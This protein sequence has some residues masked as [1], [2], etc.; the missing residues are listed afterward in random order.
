M[1]DTY[2][3]YVPSKDL[4][5]AQLQAQLTSQLEQEK[6]ELGSQQE[7]REFAAQTTAELLQE[8]GEGRRRALEAYKKTVQPRF[9]EALGQTQGATARRAAEIEAALAAD[10][11][12]QAAMGTIR[13]AASGAGI[14]AE[15]RNLA[16]AAAVRGAT[17]RG[18]DTSLALL[19]QEAAAPMDYA[20]RI[21]SALR[22]FETQAREAQIAQTVART[23]AQNVRA[24]TQALSGLMAAETGD[25]ST[26]ANLYGQTA[27]AP[28]AGSEAVIES[29]FGSYGYESPFGEWGVEY[30]WSIR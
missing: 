26:L 21:R 10:P 13:Q 12:R 1:G 29:M 8:Q 20:Q 22:P 9:I 27:Q 28:P 6:T 25:I 30:P 19:A 16:S 4:T 2:T 5:L 15:E 3:S 17:P 18:G 11:A 23:Q 24:Q 14:A 7:L